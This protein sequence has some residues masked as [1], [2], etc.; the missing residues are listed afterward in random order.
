M[1]WLF[2]PPSAP[3][4]CDTLTSSFCVPAAQIHAANWRLNAKQQTGQQN[5]PHHRRLSTL[6]TSPTL[7]LPRQHHGR[8]PFNRA[9]SNRK[10]S[11]GD[12]PS[13]HSH[14]QAAYPGPGAPDAGSGATEPG[15]GNGA[16]GGFGA[17]QPA[18]RTPC[19][20]AR[21]GPRGP[22]VHHSARVG[23]RC[24]PVRPTFD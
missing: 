5:T 1:T 17:R 7:T 2:K 13:D 6:P 8:P 10:P 24:T 18:H 23:S 15:R 12:P 11:S 9:H 14:A 19:S 3:L 16:D 22:T 21:D 20:R 4:L